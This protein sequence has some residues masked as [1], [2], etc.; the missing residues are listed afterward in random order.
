MSEI[1]TKGKA[2]KAASYL[3]NGKLLWKKMKR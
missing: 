2:A 3:I 1:R